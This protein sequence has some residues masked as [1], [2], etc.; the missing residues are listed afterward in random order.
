MAVT[1]WPTF[2]KQRA[3]L[4]GNASL[5]E[6]TYSMHPFFTTYPALAYPG[7]LKV[8]ARYTLDKSPVVY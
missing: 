1:A 6:N 7:Y 3:T 2:L 4:N 8:K 5:I